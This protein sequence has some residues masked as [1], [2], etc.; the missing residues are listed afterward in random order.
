[1]ELPDSIHDEITRLAEEGDIRADEGSYREA[2][3]KYVEA[4]ELLPEP[5]TGW[6]AST[7]LLASIGDVHFRAGNHE[8]AVTAL[9]D[10]MHCPDALGNPFIHLRLGQSQFELGNLPRANDELARAYMAAGKE[11]FDEDDPKYFQHLKTVLLPPED[12][13]W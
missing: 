4:L 10:A 12:G 2:I 1:M 6:E 13:E 3:E 7:W 8:L 9:S 5:K 11:I